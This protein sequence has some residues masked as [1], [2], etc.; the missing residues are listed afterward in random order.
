MLA[1]R[2]PVVGPGNEARLSTGVVT[3]IVDQQW[4]VDG[5]FECSR[6]TGCLLEPGVDDTVLCCELEDGIRYVLAVL[7]RPEPTEGRLSVTGAESV[8]LSAER[9]N[10]TGTEELNLRS[11]RHMQFNAALGTLHIHAQNLFS[12]VTDSLVQTAHNYIGKMSQYS[13]SALGMLRQH[14]RHQI[15]TA[16][17]DVRIDGERITMG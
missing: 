2:I 9:L 3:R 4:I 11:L 6:A 12:S 8:C 10:F 13:L 17:Q 1:T 16:D 15:V 14:G 5:A 7:H